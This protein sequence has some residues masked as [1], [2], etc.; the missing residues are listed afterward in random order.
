MTVGTND[1]LRIGRLDAHDQAELV[2]RGE[3]SR[4]ELGEAALLRIAAIDRAVNSVTYAVSEAPEP[5]GDGLLAGVP[6]LLK[7]SL[8][9][10]GWPMT[11]CSRSRAGA[12]GT[13]AWPFVGA[14]DAAGLVPVGM[15]AMPEFGLMTSGEPLLTGPVR[16]PWVPNRS[17]GGSSTG[18]AAAV[19]AGIVPLAH[20]SD[21]AGSIRIPASCNGVIGL[22]AS[23]GANL[24]ARAP[25]VIDDLLCCDGLIA[26]S[27]RDAQWAYEQ[28][29]AQGAANV[30]ARPAAGLRIGLCMAGLDGAE[31]DGDVRDAILAAAQTCLEVGCT[32]EEAALPVDGAAILRAFQTIWVHEGGEIADLIGAANPGVAPESLLEPW[33]L[34][35]ARRRAALPLDATAAAFAQVALSAAAMTHFFRS[36]DVMLSPVVPTPPPPIGLLAP[37]REFEP[38]WADFWRYTSFTPLANIAGLPAISLP[39]GM[40]GG[41]PVGAMFTADQGQDRTLLALAAALE[42]PSGWLDRRPPR[43]SIS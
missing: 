31:P 2:A 29:R 15:T 18:A 37:E 40:A 16:N 10:P 24:R 22:K 3:V 32:V 36:Y 33:T 4:A 23:R 27:A 19:A 13:T 5:K 26:R 12:V 34:S 6:Y 35:L 41:L 20:A 30:A 1:A 28:T 9:Y 43:P 17:A 21:A 38:L 25:H 39:M 14:L 11:S 42:E 7:A 8:E